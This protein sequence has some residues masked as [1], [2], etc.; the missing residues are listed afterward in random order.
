MF[1]V[2]LQDKP[3]FCFSLKSLSDECSHNYFPKLKLISIKSEGKILKSIF[4]L[5]FSS[6]KI[7]VGKTLALGNTSL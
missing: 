1:G 4:F 6:S 2:C 5:V 7:R 3:Y